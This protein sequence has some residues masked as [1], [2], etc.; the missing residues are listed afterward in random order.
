[1]KSQGF[2][3]EGENLEKIDQFT[4]NNKDQ[5]VS[6]HRGLEKLRHSDFYGLS[7]F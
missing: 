6:K 4:Q 3:F 7:Q 5:R 2:T 1:M